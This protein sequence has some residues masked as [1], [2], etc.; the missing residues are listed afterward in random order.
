MNYIKK[1]ITSGLMQP[2]AKTYW[3]KRRGWISLSSS[4][5]QVPLCRVQLP[6]TQ[7]FM[8]FGNENGA[9]QETKG[10][11]A[12][13][14]TNTWTQKAVR[15]QAVFSFLMTLVSASHFHFFRHIIS[16]SLWLKGDLPSHHHALKVLLCSPVSD[17]L[18]GSTRTTKT[19]FQILKR[20]K[21]MSSSSVRCV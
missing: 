1:H 16:T 7:I 13:E 12:R 19:K 6:V 2:Q 5:V 11:Q 20:E 10:S 8:L 15:P 9:L 14:E 17:T 18:Q 3:P 4:F 21:L